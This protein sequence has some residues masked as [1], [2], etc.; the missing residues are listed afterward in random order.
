M[1][2]NEL[3]GLNNCSGD[4]EP[5]QS[6]SAEEKK[7]EYI[8]IVHLDSSRTDTGSIILVQGLASDPIWAW[9][10]QKPRPARERAIRQD[11]GSASIDAFL[12]DRY[13]FWPRHLLP[14]DFPHARVYTYAYRSQ[15]QSDR[16]TT[17]INECGNQM[18][19]YLN[20]ERDSE[21]V[22]SIQTCLGCSLRI[23]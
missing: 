1:R 21:E 16:F 10:S 18:L 23:L 13:C 19:Y 7:V 11:L 5:D 3:W 14:T 4:P 20:R 8:T 2:A 12:D 9:R 22:R 17:D 15:H 6:R